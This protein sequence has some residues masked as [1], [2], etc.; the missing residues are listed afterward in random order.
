[1]LSCGTLSFYRWAP[2][3]DCG[4]IVNKTL[5]S[6]TRQMMQWLL[7]AGKDCTIRWHSETGCNA[8]SGLVNQLQSHFGKGQARCGLKFAIKAFLTGVS[9]AQKDQSRSRHLCPQASAPQRLHPYFWPWPE[10]QP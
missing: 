10:D 2:M 3:S 1:M 6:T 9:H 5:A 7:S 8:H 4:L